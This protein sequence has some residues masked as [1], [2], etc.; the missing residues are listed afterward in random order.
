MLR[1]VQQL[2]YDNYLRAD[3]GGRP[4][5]YRQLV[6]QMNQPYLYAD[7][8]Y[9]VPFGWYANPLPSTCATAWMVMLADRF[10]PLRPAGGAQAEPRAS[11]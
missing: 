3:F 8:R 10:D 6:P 5:H 4:A 9:L 1:A 11:R 7:R 2:R